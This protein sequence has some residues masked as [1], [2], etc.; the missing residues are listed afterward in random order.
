MADKDDRALGAFSQLKWFSISENHINREET[1]FV[2]TFR[3]AASP[4]ARV[5]AWW[6]IWSLEEPSLKAATSAL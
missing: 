1:G 4:E 6:W 3:L 5:S 2:L